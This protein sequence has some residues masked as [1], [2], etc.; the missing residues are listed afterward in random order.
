MPVLAP[1]TRRFALHVSSVLLF[2]LGVGTLVLSFVTFAGG[3]AGMSGR[4]MLTGLIALALA[5]TLIVIVVVLQVLAAQT[6]PQVTVRCERCGYDLRVV[7][8]SSLPQVAPSANRFRSRR[9]SGSRHCLEP[10]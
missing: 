1:T 2:L 10:S 3:L 6:E 9:K 5:V 8:V 7:T 4:R